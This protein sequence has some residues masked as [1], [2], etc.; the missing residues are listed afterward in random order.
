MIFKMKKMLVGL[1]GSVFLISTMIAP[2]SAANL[3][4]ACENFHVYIN[5]GSVVSSKTATK[6]ISGPMWS[7]AR[8]QTG[9]SVNWLSSEYVNLRGRTN[10]GVKCTSLGKTNTPG[11]TVY[12]YY[13]SGYGTLYQPYRI[14]VQYDNS[15][16]Y[17]HLELT[18][19]WSP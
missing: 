13:N 18:V 11:E 8:K 5:G 19:C 14:A 1:V 9:S 4:E 15:N 12:L 2:A 7:N 17:T 10:S 3:G 6:E 16:P